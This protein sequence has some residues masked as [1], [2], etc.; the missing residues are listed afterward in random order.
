MGAL[1]DQ[2]GNKQPGELIQFRG[3]H[4]HVLRIGAIA[5]HELN[6]SLRAGQLYLLGVF[7]IQ[8]QGHD[9]HLL[10]RALTPPCTC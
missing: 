2:F 1:L 6:R 3:M 7:R 4:V 9:V 10:A 5:K 8:Q